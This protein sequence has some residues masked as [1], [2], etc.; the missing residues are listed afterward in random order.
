MSRTTDYVLEHDID[1]T[2]PR[3]DYQQ[4]LSEDEGYQEWSDLLDEERSEEVFGEYST[5]D[6]E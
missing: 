3:E 1:L 6:T 2:D 4:I 5:E